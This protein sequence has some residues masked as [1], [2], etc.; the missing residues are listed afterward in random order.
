MRSCVCHWMGVVV[1]KFV[2]PSVQL[3]RIEACGSCSSIERRRRRRRSEEEEEEETA[4]DI[5]S[6]EWRTSVPLSRGRAGSVELD[7]DDEEGEFE[8][9]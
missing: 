3:T 9:E 1:D 4:S 5:L 6:I 8:E 7:D 2:S